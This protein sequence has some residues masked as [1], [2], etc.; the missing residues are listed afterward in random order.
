MIA[1]LLQL[2]SRIIWRRL[3]TSRDVQTINRAAYFLAAGCI[4]DSLKKSPEIRRRMWLA[5]L[6][7]QV[8]EWRDSCGGD[9]ADWR[10]R[11][12]R[13]AQIANSILTHAF[14]LCAAHEFNF[15]RVAAALG[16]NRIDEGDA[17]AQRETLRDLYRHCRNEFGDRVMHGAKR[18][19][20]GRWVD[21]LSAACQ[22]HLQQ[23]VPDEDTDRPDAAGMIFQLQQNLQMVPWNA[24]LGIDDPAIQ[25]QMRRHGGNVAIRF[26]ESRTKRGRERIN[27]DLPRI[28]ND[29]RQGDPPGSGGDSDGGQPIGGPP[30]TGGGEF[31]QLCQKGLAEQNRAGDLENAE[32][33]PGSSCSA[34]NASSA[35]LFQKSPGGKTKEARSGEEQKKLSAKT[36]AEL[37][38]RD[39]DP[40]RGG[41]R[42]AELPAQLAE[43]LTELAAGSPQRVPDASSPHSVLSRAGFP[44]QLLVLDF[45]TYFDGPYSLKKMTIPEYVHDARFRAH[46]IAIRWPDGRC[47]FRPDIAEALLELRAEFGDRLGA[48]TVMCHHA[49]FDGY[50]LVK[51][52][53]LT[54]AYVTDT[55]AMARQV[56]PGVGHKLADLAQRYGLQ[57][58]GDALD[59]LEGVREP[60]PGQLAKLAAYARHDAELCYSI[61]MRLLP[62]FSRPEIELKLIDHTVR[63]FTER[64]LPFDL[65][66]ARK[67]LQKAKKE[68]QAV[69]DTAGVDRKTAGG[70]R[71]EALLAA[72]L[73]KS[74]RRLPTKVGKNGQIPALAKGDG[75]MK[76]LLEDPNPQVQRLACARLAVKSAPQV[77]NR[78]KTMIHIAEATGGV[79]PVPLKYHGC[80]TGRYSGDDGINLQNLPAHIKGL[81]ARIRGLL[82]AGDGHRLVIVD[83][84]QIEARVLAWFAGQQDLLQEFGQDGDPYSRFATRIFG[85]PIRKPKGDDP[86]DVQDHLGPR[87][88]LGKTC[89]LGLGYQAGVERF[90]RMVRTDPKVGP[91]L[92]NGTLTDAFLTEV[93]RDYRRN[94]TQVVQ[95]WRVT[96]NAFANALGMGRDVAR[97]V[98]ITR[99]SEA[100]YI[101][102]PSG[103]RLFYP[104]PHIPLSGEMRYSGGKL[105][106]GLLVE[107]V[108][109][110]IARDI[111]V[112]AML[113]LEQRGYET[114][115]TVHDEV[116]LRVPTEAAEKAKGAAI[117]CMSTT[118]AWAP[119]LP[120]AAEGRVADRYGK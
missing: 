81:A 41:N 29:D 119:G 34:S 64:A 36:L 22:E 82:R 100:A 7:R 84:A 91:L 107:N 106:G 75:G 97:C 26:V 101:H 17:E 118:P 62:R 69:L 27:E 39:F 12:K 76:Q 24:V 61:A 71:L 70:K 87:R 109:Q 1:L 47:D 95:A 57:S 50:I 49:H 40:A 96:Q 112:E 93:H 99:D 37:A 16:L 90:I 58:K 89:I 108:I 33:R 111:L 43:Q 120:L 15:D 74:G 25:C 38:E 103:R 98:S 56:F 14:N 5:R 67:L 19:Q 32:N 13:N 45:E 88:Q 3:Y 80:H 55:L 20:Q 86:P 48:V 8:P 115:L 4:P 60:S 11:S 53:G 35:S 42:L 116:V 63:M 72:E 18:Y 28:P 66:G 94:Y 30:S 6:P 68:L 73:E 104:D 51:R 79:M 117:E 59:E 10:A 105:Y 65:E 85:E 52:Y 102:L 113:A 77:E 83:A 9:T 92:E 23:L 2:S 31:C 46:G 21:A 110:G 78:L 114:V 54:P 44:P